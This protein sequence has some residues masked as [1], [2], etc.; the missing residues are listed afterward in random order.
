MELLAGVAKRT[1]LDPFSKQIYGIKRKGKLCIQTGIDGFRVIAGRTGELDGQ[2]GPF[3]CG[4][5]GVW[6]DVWLDD[7][8][9]AAAKVVVYRKGC[10]LPFTGIARFREYSTGYD[11][12]QR[13][14]ANQIAK[15]AEALALRKAFPADLSGL[16]VTEEMDQSEDGPTP[17]PE[18]KPAKKPATTVQVTEVKAESKPL[19]ALTLPNATAA[20]KAV[21]VIEKP[22]ESSPGAE[23]PVNNVADLLKL[24]YRKGFDWVGLVKQINATFGTSYNPTRDWAKIKLEH[25]TAAVAA[26]NK[27]PDENSAEELA[28]LLAEVAKL[29]G[30]T[31]P[32]AIFARFCA[33]AKLPESC[34]KPEDLNGDQLKTA[35][36]SFRTKLTKMK[37]GA[38]K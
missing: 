6:R 12:W 19:P 1:G 7:T 17:E 13:M 22:S 21:E 9:P 24:L 38:Q 14:P 28:Q 33:A 25:R 27:K 16:Y 23:D 8:P 18:P 35:C 20:A 30:A 29:E 15:C 4:K 3:W 2:D 34:V 32:D 36:N 31:N 26:L 11:F 5:D 37:E 10:K